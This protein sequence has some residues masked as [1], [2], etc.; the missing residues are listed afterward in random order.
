MNSRERVL[1]ALDHKEPDRVPIDFAGTGVT[2][3]CYQA[4]D[5]VRRCLGMKPTNWKHEDLG[6]AA[7][8]GVVA[9]HAEVYDRLHSDV[10]AVGMGSPD[11]WKLEIQYGD[12]FDTYIDE[13]GT[14]L[15]KP[16]GG[17]YFDYRDFPIKK[18]TVEDV[19][20]WKKWPDPNDPGRWRGF[21][22]RCQDALATG[23]AI[24]AFSV[25]GGGIFEQPA[26]IMPMEEY[27]MGLVSDQ[28]F[29]DLILG[30]MF[31]IYYESTKR[32]LEEVGDIL[33]VWV[34]WDDLSTQ[35]GPI[36]SPK[37]YAKNL[38]PL[39]RK[40]FDYVKSKTKAKIFFHCCGAA[41]P[42]I[43]YFID[44]GVDILNPVQTSA[45]GMDPLGL[46]RDFG[47]DIV[48]WGGACNPQGV[49]AFGTP[50][51]VAREVRQNIDALAPGGGF[52]LGNVH[53]IQN[54]VPGEN[55]ISMFDTAYDYGSY[56]K[57]D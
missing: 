11:T 14:R 6:G 40:L 44:V 43:P 20:S 15:Y 37:W 25:F 23:R 51:G 7:W 24:T 49:L 41:R 13:W 26:R 19:R 29:T 21:R 1:L 30:K 46:K 5:D 10:Q 55:I 36:I 28:S 32:M 27:F 54:M 35:T 50:E 38:M 47:R 12:V 42:W 56:K 39:H 45:T 4:Y 31:E 52:I 53:N 34:Y 22:Q 48:F 33:D 16:K 18:A 3:I 17:H 9:P 57:G 8:A 2:G